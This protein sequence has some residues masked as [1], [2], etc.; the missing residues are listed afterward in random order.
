MKTLHTKSI[1]CRTVVYRYGARR[2]QC[3]QCKRTWRV[4]KK[5]RGRKSIRVHPSINKVAL[6]S[7]ETLRH[8]AKRISKGRE[9]IRRR[10]HK[11]I[12]LLLKKL[13]LQKAPRGE[14][15]AI[16]D[17]KWSRFDAKTY[18]T[19]EILLRATNGSH[20]LAVEPVFLQGRESS[21][22]WHH[23]FDCLPNSVQKRI[24]VVVSDGIT[25]I[26]ALARHRGWLV[27]RCHFHL[28]ATLQPM[29]GKRWAKVRQKGLRETMYQLI[30]RAISTSN[31]HE[32]QCILTAINHLVHDP[33]F[34]KWYGV[35]VR[36]FLRYAHLFRTYR[37]YPEYNIPTTTNAIE[38]VF[39]QISET[40]RQTRGFR[41]SESYQRWI[42]IQIRML[43]GIRCNG[44]NYQP[45]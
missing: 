45:N 2:R 8:R 14:L 26:E 7:Q 38:A 43:P 19:Y 32:A 24:R 34:P 10:H 18:T 41:N 44:H 3:V 22:G 31:D 23:A 42:T 12:G 25:G 39:K 30:Y 6:P 5:K 33:R 20:A 21:P 40:I 1:C 9:I 11:N 29:R 28:L 37:N 27:Q 4:R 16:V 36:G 35:K 17:G 13:P 15:I